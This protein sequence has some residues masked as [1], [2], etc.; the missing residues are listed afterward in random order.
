MIYGFVVTVLFLRQG[1]MRP[2]PALKLLCSQ[3]LE[4]PGPDFNANMEIEMCATKHTF[5]HMDVV[6]LD[7]Y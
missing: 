4:P 2:M 7:K 5:Y 6:E 1:L 3:D